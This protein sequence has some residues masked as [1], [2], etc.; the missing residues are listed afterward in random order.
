MNKTLKHLVSFAVIAVFAF[1]ILAIAQPASAQLNVGLNDS[2]VTGIGLGSKDP[3]AIA[4][5]VI[6]LA[7]GFLGLIAVVICLIGGFKWMTA[8]GNEEQVGEAK[9][10]LG[11]GL[12]GLVIIL[13]AYGLSTYVITQ[14]MSA[15]S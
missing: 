12:I 3:K 11:A 6:K 14:L 10:L 15:T 5:Y 7:L 8:A 4:N 2:N 13:T 9:K 1:G